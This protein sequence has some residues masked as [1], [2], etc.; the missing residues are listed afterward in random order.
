VL[1]EREAV[2]L[3]VRAVDVHGVVYVDVV[4]GFPDRTVAQARLGSESVPDALT[5]GETVLA[6]TVMGQLVSLRRVTRETGA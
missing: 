2:V 5:T 1:G 3:E 4:V 6:S